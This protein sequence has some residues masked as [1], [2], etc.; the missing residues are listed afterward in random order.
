MPS[1]LGDLTLAPNQDVGSAHEASKVLAR[2]FEQEPNGN[3]EIRIHTG[4]NHD[5]VVTVPLPA[6][7]LL[8][9]VLEEI[10][11]GN[12]VTIRRKPNELTTQQAADLMQ[13]S[14]P[15]VVKLLEQG[16]IPFRKV[17]SFRRIPYRELIQYM[18]QED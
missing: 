10:A 15:F 12:S 14:R 3:A 2:L 9:D 5:A 17:G 4:G 7:G 16:K 6:I 18:E 8:S 11:N 13:V 1:I